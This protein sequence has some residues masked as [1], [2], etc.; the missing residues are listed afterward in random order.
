MSNLSNQAALSGQSVHSPSIEE[1]LVAFVKEPLFF[2]AK[3]RADQRATA[4]DLLRSY[5]CY[6]G[7]AWL[8]AADENMEEQRRQLGPT[9]QRSLQHILSAEKIPL[10]LPG[11]FAFLSREISPV[12][13][14]TFVKCA[15]LAMEELSLWLIKNG[16]IDPE[17]GEEAAY[18]ACQAGRNLPRAMRALKR[19]HQE[20]Q[21]FSE[22]EVRWTAE[23]ESEKYTIVRLA[24]KLL[25]LEDENGEKVGPV[26]I[27]ENT[28][29][30]L[31]T[32][33]EL[34]CCLAQVQGRWIL[35]GLG[36]IFVPVC[37]S[38]QSC[39]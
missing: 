31:E 30:D 6:H 21:L 27:S 19:L 7:A 25:Y 33:W 35:T 17:I 3:L 2:A 24:P 5:I 16:H 26:R 23:G 1:T 14:Q 32:G 4:V 11:F 20:A 13:S 38:F 12:A 15:C 8:A 39:Q 36:G 37:G 9:G 22:Q 18:H 34:H 29:R 10:L 28:R